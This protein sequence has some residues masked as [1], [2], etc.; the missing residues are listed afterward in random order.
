MFP[1][2]HDL[3]EAFPLLAWRGCWLPACTQW[4]WNC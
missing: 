4:I 2:A 1:R 3:I